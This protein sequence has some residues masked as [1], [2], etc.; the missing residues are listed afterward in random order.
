MKVDLPPPPWATHLQSDLTDWYKA[1]VP[2]SELVPFE[3]PD[4]AFFEYAWQ[5]KAGERRADPANNNPRTN[6]W[7]DFACHLTGPDYRPDPWV[8]AAG[9]RPLGRVLRLRIASVYFPGDRQVLVYS[10]PGEAESSLA[11]IYFQDGKAY[12]GWGRVSQVLDRLMA[13]GLVPAAHLVFV[14][15]SQRTREYGFNDDYLRHMVEEVLPTVES[16]V[17]CNGR[18]TA[19]GASLGGLCSA[20]L[21]WDY[22]ELFQSVVSQSGAYLFHPGMDYTRPW[23]GDSAFVQRVQSEPARPLAWY[24]DCGTLEWLTASNVQMSVALSE[25]GMKVEAVLRNAGHNWE[26]WRNGLADGLISVLGSNA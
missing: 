15:P 9:V 7:W 22:P 13:A 12:Y 20:Y 23:V 26:N 10:P 4:D 21:A 16:R 19:W 6:P 3:L 5:D 14:T 18:R 17:A 24:L 25:S 11:T 8:V 1:P 2:V